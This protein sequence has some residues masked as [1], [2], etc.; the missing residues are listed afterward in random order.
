MGLVGTFFR[1]MD[2]DL[3]QV[4]MGG[5]PPTFNFVPFGATCRPADCRRE[6]SA[7]RH[8]SLSSMCDS[9][10]EGESGRIEFSERTGYKSANDGS[11][12]RSIQHYLGHRNI[13]STIGIHPF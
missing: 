7:G 1:H 11:D 10:L 9:T 12:T 5:C 4:P 3:S 13:Q 8:I 6:S 2:F